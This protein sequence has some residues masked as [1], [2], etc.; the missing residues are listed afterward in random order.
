[1]ND[2]EFQQLLSPYREIRDQRVKPRLSFY[3]E[4]VNSK[5]FCAQGTSVAILFL[6]LAIP[7]VTNL[8]FAALGLSKLIIS[9]MSLLIALI[10]G[11]NEVFRWQHLWKEYSERI[12]Q[13][14]TLI[15]L[16]EI[17][18]AKARH[19]SDPEKI[20][21]KLGEATEELVKSVET[22]VLTEMG[23]FFPTTPKKQTP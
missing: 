23:T 1:M 2:Q 4:R 6:S 16:W 18:V 7:I 21:E 13:I 20:S 8:D 3:Q 12:V 11:L 9:A 19:L 10:T 5:R 22:A 17:E 14:D 15:G